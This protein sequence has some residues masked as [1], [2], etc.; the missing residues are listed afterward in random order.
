MFGLRQLY[1]F[2]RFH[3]ECLQFYNTTGCEKVF[4]INSPKLRLFIDCFPLI[5]RYFNEACLFSRQHKQYDHNIWSTEFPLWKYSRAK[6]S[7]R[8]AT[9]TNLFK[10]SRELLA[11]EI[12]FFFDGIEA[13]NVFVS[14]SLLFPYCTNYQLKMFFDR[15][16]LTS[17]QE[18]KWCDLQ[19]N[20]KKQQ[21]KH[22]SK[23]E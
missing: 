11:S 1:Y 16:E 18:R 8:I 20:C 14:C 19:L 3:V 9:V 12:E 13:L 17:C 10:A 4:F 15:M 5:V 23:T 21:K 7:T 22:R 2:L 6:A